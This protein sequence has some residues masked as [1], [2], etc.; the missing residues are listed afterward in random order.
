MERK[1]LITGGIRSGKSLFAISSALLYPQPR[2]FLATAEPLDQE[3][4]KRI[5]RHQAERKDQFLTVEEPLDLAEKILEMK[6]SSPSPLEKGDG[7]GVIVIDCLTVWLGNLYQYLEDSES[8]IQTRTNRLV[9]VVKNAEWNMIIITNEVGL[10]VISDQPLGRHFVDALG[11]LNQELARICNE[12]VVMS[13][14]IPKIIK[15]TLQ[16]G[17]MDCSIATH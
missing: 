3:M 6:V 1:V 14:G 4:R 15:G 12:V 9:E 16:N 2:V 10:G 11:M 17:K 7:K 5:L 13:C 8:A